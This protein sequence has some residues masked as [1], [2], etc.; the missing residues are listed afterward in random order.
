MTS[1]ACGIPEPPRTRRGL[2]P[3]RRRSRPSRGGTSIVPPASS[4]SW[5][6]TTTSSSRSTSPRP[7]GEAGDPRATRRLSGRLMNRPAGSPFPLP[8][9]AGAF[10]EA[11]AAARRRQAAVAEAGLYGIDPLTATST[12]RA[13]NRGRSR[14]HRVSRRLA[15][16]GGPTSLSHWFR[17][18]R[19]IPLRRRTRAP[20]RLLQPASRASPE[21]LRFA[22]RHVSGRS[23]R[24]PRWR[25]IAPRRSR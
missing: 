6:C 4:A 16:T 13:R 25:A 23:R 22:D 20:R 7:P 5:S 2:G 11:A 19:R 12:T 3:F 21:R 10:P 17:P 9:P 14:S 8:S 24:F 1:R 15:R 18:R